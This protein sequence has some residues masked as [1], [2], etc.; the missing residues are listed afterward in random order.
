MPIRAALGHVPLPAATLRTPASC[1]S[2]TSPPPPPPSSPQ[3]VVG[4]ATGAGIIIGAYFAFYSTTKQCLRKST[5]MS[6]GACARVSAWRAWCARR[7]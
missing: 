1:C 2:L 7:G 4:A 3:G 5:N 6:E